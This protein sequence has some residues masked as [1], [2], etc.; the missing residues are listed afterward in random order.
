MTF[1]NIKVLV[2]KEISEKTTACYNPV[3]YVKAGLHFAGI[4]TP[5][6]FFCKFRGSSPIPAPCTVFFFN[7][8]FNVF[9]V[10]L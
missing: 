8:P 9:T 1:E 6:L 7:E 5:A 3:F 2:A 4:E 10:V